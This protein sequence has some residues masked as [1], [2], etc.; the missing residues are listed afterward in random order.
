[1]GIVARDGIPDLTMQGVAEVVGCSIGT[2]YTHFASKGVLVADLQ[3]LSVRRIARSFEAARARNAVA[4]DAVAATPMERA[5]AD[6]VLFGEF[7]VACWDALPE[8]SHMLFSVLAERA[9]VV[10]AAELGRVLGPTLALLDMG[11]EAVAGA[12]LADAVVDG[13]AMDRVIIGA[14][15]LLGVLLTSHLAHLNDDAFDHRRLARSAWR[16]MLRGWGMSE[17]LY[18]WS[19][20]HVQALAA[21]GSLAAVPP[22]EE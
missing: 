9:V 8:E 1:M 6:L 3:D 14:A 11:R 2:V 10:P 20:A 5:G 7:V 21:N 19:L 18:H 4:L 15:A 12:A 17:P 22:D 13:P 16:D